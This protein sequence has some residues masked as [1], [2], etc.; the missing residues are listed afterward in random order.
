MNDAHT[1]AHVLLD[2]KARNASSR[3]AFSAGA[4]EIAA[5]TAQGTPMKEPKEDVVALDAKFAEQWRKA[6]TKERNAGD[7]NRTPKGSSSA[8]TRRG[9]RPPRAP[10]QRER[11]L[12]HVVAALA[13][14]PDKFKNLAV[15]HEY[16]RAGEVVDLIV[17]R[18]QKAAAACG[19]LSF[20]MEIHKW[21]SPPLNEPPRELLP[22]YEKLAEAWAEVANE[23]GA[24]RSTGIRVIDGVLRSPLTQESFLR[25]IGG[26]P[27]NV[28]LKKTPLL[29][30]IDMSD[31]D[32]GAFRRFGVALAER[33]RFLVLYIEHFGER[34][35][36]GLREGETGRIPNLALHYLAR[37][38]DEK[39]I[40]PAPLA[41]HIVNN[42]HLRDPTESWFPTG[43]EIAPEDVDEVVEKWTTAIK[44]AL[45]AY[46]QR[47]NAKQAKNEVPV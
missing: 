19:D 18:M 11:L 33:A 9:A 35:A 34:E 10:Q 42:W 22:Y 16:E 29:L 8:S 24:F 47:H 2:R 40:G 23:E 45:Y 13:E 25:A 39:G 26:I 30:R 4:L 31:A 32:A 46:R 12:P 1:E 7:K 28:E 17:R 3:D 27:H 37:W 41:R 14:F 21:P 43:E 44:N 38:A 36:A 6:S 20:Q 5:A 15:T